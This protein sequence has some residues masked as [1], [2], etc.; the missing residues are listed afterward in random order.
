MSLYILIGW[1]ERSPRG[2]NAIEFLIDVIQKYDQSELGVEAVAEFAK[3]GLK[4]P[5]LT[6]EER[7]V[8]TAAPTP[9]PANRGRRHQMEG[10]GDEGKN[11][12]RLPLQ[13]SEHP[14]N[15]FDHSVRSPYN[16][17]SR[18]WSASHNGVVH[19]LRFT[20]TRLRTDKKTPNPMR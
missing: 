16:N 5:P 13:V 15:D 20:P 8:S 17:T 12:R 19:E 10:S 2:E 3:T 18:S 6:E 4:P 11:D 9:P 1:G 7:S 14:V